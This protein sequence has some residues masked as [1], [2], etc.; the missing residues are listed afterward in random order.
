MFAHKSILETL[1][2]EVVG[3]EPMSLDFVDMA[4]AGN[5][6]AQAAGYLSTDEIDQLQACDNSNTAN[7]TSWGTNGGTTGA[8]CGCPTRYNR[9]DDFTVAELGLPSLATLTAE[10]AER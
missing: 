3:N 4:S 2:K 9:A 6:R 10:L 1:P 8:S 7:P 5:L